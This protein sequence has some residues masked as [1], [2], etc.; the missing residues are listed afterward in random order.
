VIFDSGC[1]AVLVL[2]AADFWEK[3]IDKWGAF[4]VYYTLSYAREE[5]EWAEKTAA[6]LSRRACFTRGRGSF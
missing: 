5:R 1:G 4:M 3:G 6:K 2:S